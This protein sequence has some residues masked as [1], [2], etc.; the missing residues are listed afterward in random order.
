MIKITKLQT[1]DKTGLFLQI[2]VTKSE[3]AIK[4]EWNNS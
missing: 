3:K 4:I 1:K 2:I